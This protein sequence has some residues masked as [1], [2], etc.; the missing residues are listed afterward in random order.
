MI[1]GFR[2]R[3]RRGGVVVGRGDSR[4]DR[5]GAAKGEETRTVRLLWAFND[6]GDSKIFLFIIRLFG[7]GHKT[8]TI[9]LIHERQSSAFP[10]GEQCPRPNAK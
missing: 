1:G 10:T 8:H 5:V 6:L 4:D 2:R 3:G 7:P 9:A